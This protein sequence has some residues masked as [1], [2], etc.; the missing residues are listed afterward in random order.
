[1]STVGFVVEPLTIKAA[2]DAIGSPLG[3]ASKMPCATFGL[4]AA[5]CKTGSKLAKV[6]GSI[7]A[8]CYADP[9]SGGNYAYP[10]VTTSHARRLDALNSTLPAAWVAA[11]VRLITADGLPWF[12]W[13]DSG[14]VQSVS[15]LAAIVEI[16]RALPSVQ[17]WLP[18]KEY[19]LVRFYL[20]T[21]GRFPDNLTVRL[22][23]PMIGEDLPASLKGLGLPY[24]VAVRH[25]SPQPLDDVEPCRAY[26]DPDKPGACDDCRACWDSS[27][28]VSY[29]VH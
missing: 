20:S 25:G 21:L 26:S 9:Q 8:E 24:S 6:A 3:S 18:T 27:L 7:C 22:S 15:H 16:A 28:T 11:M 29:T 4:S 17:F 14:D 10:S 2:V 12:R 23:A 1:L 19:Q 5:H 13:H